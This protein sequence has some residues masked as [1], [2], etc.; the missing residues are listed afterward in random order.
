[1]KVH[2]TKKFIPTVWTHF[3]Y[4]GLPLRE[5]LSMRSN[6]LSSTLVRFTIDAN[7]NTAYTFPGKTCYRVVLGGELIKRVA[8]LPDNLTSKAAVA[9]HLKD[10]VYAINGLALHELGHNLFTDMSSKDVVDYPKR[11][12]INFLH[13]LINILEDPIV[14]ANM[15][16]L[17]R[18]RYPKDISPNVY[19]TLM[20]NQLFVD[21]AKTY[22]DEE[23]V[24]SFLNYILLR[25]RLGKEFTKKNTIFE[26]YKDELNKRIIEVVGTRK[27]T[28]RLHKE[29]ALGEYIIEHI[30]ELDFKTTEEPKEKTARG[31]GGG[32]SGIRPKDSEVSFD[33]STAKDISDIA[34]GGSSV[35]GAGSTDKPEEG[36]EAGKGSCEDEDEGKEEKKEGG[37]DG[38]SKDDGIESESVEMDAEFEDLLAS[39]GLLEHDYHEW[40]IAK[41]DITP[42]DGMLEKI[43]TRI[44]D[45]EGPAKEISKYLTLI[46][47]RKKP[48]MAHGF[49][50]GKL[51]L[52]AAMQD[53][54]RD[55][56]N[57][58]LFDRPIRRGKQPD[59]AIW[60][61]GDNSGS[62]SGERSEITAKAMLALAQACDWA[63]VPFCASC[64]TKT[65]DCTEGTCVTIVEK[66]F[67]DSFE[68]SKPFFAINDSHLVG[69]MHTDKRVPFFAGNSEEVNIYAVWK[70][71]TQNEHKTKIL[72]VLC[73]GQT[74]GSSSDLKRVIHSATA[75]GLIV[76]G[77]GIC[78]SDVQHL[79]PIHKVFSNQEALD[80]ELAPYLLKVLEEYCS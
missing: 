47:G 43:N 35:P 71:F 61:L 22:K 18:I 58:K 73:D 50:T 20:K 27:A 46:N 56:C 52:R 5:F 63:K 37:E 7:K 34:D 21:Q 12:Y 62:M 74:T 19:F 69:G 59:V 64:F 11:E 66:D 77:I 8:N 65:S 13:S 68:S 48:R 39:D 40:V 10:T 24:G 55:G 44:K 79:Y 28:E 25:L 70:K 53:D 38:D 51:N 60:L 57:L 80:K 4:R 9:A 31:I 30:K 36:K 76:I 15:C 67:K 32:T 23:T 49:T 14:E 1:M 2:A 54:I 6:M 33:G 42:S 41:D 16:Q 72:I 78:S 3:K 17:W 26:K 29:I 45:V 75:D